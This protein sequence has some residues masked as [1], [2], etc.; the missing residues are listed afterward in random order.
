MSLSGASSY[1]KRFN[2]QNRTPRK[3]PDNPAFDL[4]EQD[5]VGTHAG[6]M[7]YDELA[8]WLVQELD[9]AIAAR[10]NVAADIAYRWTYYEQ[11][12]TRGS[13]A[14]WPD[15]ADLTSPYATEFVDAVLGRVMDTIMVDTVWIVDG[16]G[17]SSKRAP[18]VEEFHQ[19]TLEQER[20]QTYLRDALL[21]SFI[22]P[23]GILEITEAMDLRR[24]R[25][26]IKARLQLDPAT[27]APIIGEDTQPVLQ[28]D[29]TGRYVE[30]QTPDEPHAETVI[31]DLRPVRL[32]PAYSV[33][34][35]QDYHS[36]P[37]HARSTD[38]IW[39]YAKR[40]YRRVPELLARAK[41]GIYDLEAV[42]ALGESD[43][44]GMGDEAIALD[45]RG[46]TAQKEL[47][48]MPFLADLDGEGERWWIATVSR[49]TTKLLRLKVDDR[50]ARFLE[51]V[52][53]PKP[54]SR[55]GYSLIEKMMTLLEEDT[56]VRN[57]RADRSSLAVSAPM[58]RMQGSLW[59]PYEQPMGPGAVIDVRDPKEI[60]PMVIPDVPQS[61]N[62][63]KTDIR[64][65]L[66]RLVGM[67]DVSNG[68]ETQER[69]TLGEVQLTA[70]YSEV[71][72]KAI[73][74][75]IQETL[76]ELGAARHAIW[77]R[78]LAEQ[79]QGLPI[80]AGMMSGLD[81]RGIDIDT[82]AD[83]RVTADMLEGQ[84]WFKPRGSTETANL[85][86]QAQYFT[87]LIQTFQQLAQMNPMIAALLQTPQAA[88]A[89][90]EQMLRVARWP[91]KQA[92][93]GSEAQQ[94]M[95]QVSQQQ[96]LQANPMMQAMMQMAGAGGSAGT[97]T[98]GGV[99]EAPPPGSP[100]P[101]GV[102]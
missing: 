79:P 55:D 75:A 38:E 69:R 44:R 72:V 25:K 7:K 52:P 16:W 11:G 34:A 57:M 98:G 42:Q 82:I 37:Y 74:K 80:P 99:S 33:I 18:F 30:V 93:L 56:A 65:D 88:K 89:M 87:A 15:A 2:N 77:K 28:Q 22:E 45:Q 20:L 9:A 51:F 47:Y 64:T 27:Q 1:N 81:A 54:G 6:V 102:M 26:T 36:L 5:L 60:T 29:E 32:G 67:G 70:T 101:A 94:V 35:Y 10:G 23:R 58:L 83:G 90:V 48:E 3:K 84:F 97:G 46:P 100:Q 68:T 43:E 13:G 66:E 50:T 73:I 92:F 95:Q 40:F 78:V 76:E 14:P 4:R 53:F 91:D 61:I 19:R 39:G 96:A 12:R 62:I 8:Q 86:R 71:R 49:L 24:E 85:D 59:N 17:E 63:W 41:Q 31:D 21:R